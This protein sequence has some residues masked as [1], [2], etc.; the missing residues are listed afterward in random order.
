MGYQLHFEYLACLS[1]LICRVMSLNRLFQDL[2]LPFQERLQR[3]QSI[4]QYL[5]PIIPSPSTKDPMATSTEELSM[6]KSEAEE[7]SKKGTAKNTSMK[8]FFAVEVMEKVESI[9]KETV[10][11]SKVDVLATEIKKAE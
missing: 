2:L 9:T 6:K 7:N 10:E 4:P 8:D 11:Y 1:L 3:L 5:R